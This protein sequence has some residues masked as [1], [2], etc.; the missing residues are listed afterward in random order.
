MKSL[1]SMKNAVHMA[2]IVAGRMAAWSN[3][4]ADYG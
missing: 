3:A 1:I 4:D 2:A